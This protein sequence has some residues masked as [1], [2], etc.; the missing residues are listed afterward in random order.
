MKLVQ[1]GNISLYVKKYKNAYGITTGKKWFPYLYST[2]A[3]AEKVLDAIDR[4]KHLD[5]NDDSWRD[6]FTHDKPFM[7]SL[8]G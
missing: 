3:K 8:Q 2:Q 7:G 5:D 1:I 4:W 6:R